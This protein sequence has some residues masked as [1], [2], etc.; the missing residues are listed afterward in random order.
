MRSVKAILLVGV[1]FQLVA[2]LDPKRNEA[3]VRVV[4]AYIENFLIYDRFPDDHASKE[5]QG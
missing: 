1:S 4:D 3:Q 2:D 5:G